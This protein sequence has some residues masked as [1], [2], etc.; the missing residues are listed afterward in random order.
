MK[1]EIKTRIPMSTRG[2]QVHKSEN[3]YSRKDEKKEIE[4][5]LNENS[6]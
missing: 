2:T 1:N 4:K 3:D 5:D 6:E